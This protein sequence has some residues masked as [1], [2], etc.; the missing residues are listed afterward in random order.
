MTGI[1]YG[2]GIFLNFQMDRLPPI[3]VFWGPQNVTAPKERS[4]TG[5]DSIFGQ[6]TSLVRGCAMQSHL[7]RRLRLSGV[8]ES[9]TSLGHR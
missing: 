7:F 1:S 4:V 2:F 3:P 5:I 9:E 8:Q 6:Y